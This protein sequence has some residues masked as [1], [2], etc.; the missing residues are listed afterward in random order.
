MTTATQ[1]TNN[2]PVKAILA[3]QATTMITRWRRQLE[4]KTQ[5]LT[6]VRLV[7]ETEDLQAII[8][9]VRTCRYF[10]NPQKGA[11]GR[12]TFSREQAA[13]K[14][15]YALTLPRM[16]AVYLP[17]LGVLKGLGRC[18]P[19]IKTITPTLRQARAV[20]IELE[21][22]TEGWTPLHLVA[23]L[24]HLEKLTHLRNAGANL[25]AVTVSGSR[26]KF[27]QSALSIAC[28]S[29][30]WNAATLL[31]EMRA[32]VNAG[33]LIPL[34]WA[35]QHANAAM[36]ATLLNARA[37]ANINQSEPRPL[38]MAAMAG[39]ASIVQLLLKH[40]ADTEATHA[41]CT[42]LLIAAEND[43]RATVDLL[44][45][46]GASVNSKD[47]DGNS[48]LHQAAYFGLTEVAQQLLRAGAP[49]DALNAEGRTPLI[50]VV[51]K[52]PFV[53]VGQIPTVTLL[54]NHKA[55]PHLAD[56]LGRTPLWYARGN[57]EVIDLLR[58]ASAIPKD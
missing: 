54:L 13:L 15:T 43:H 19:L 53:R 38:Y 56:N 33:D 58:N 4:D 36:V 12:W 55:D 23:Q 28:G 31:L 40:K 37:D 57:D 10:S 34:K 46:A 50:R 48:P 30:D 14:A 7:Q 51:R 16:G 32:D 8:S 24:G 47:K 27:V 18:L 45:Q 17:A 42:A 49:V 44:L 52:G 26:S 3:A 1:A 21:T 9:I 39:L 25:D 29:R 5:L 20:V 41:G 35:V 22:R 6:L 11:D 2:D